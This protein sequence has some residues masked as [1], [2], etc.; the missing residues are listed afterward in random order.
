MELVDVIEDAGK[1]GKDLNREGVKELMDS[2][3]GRQVNA[4]IV[5]KL[6]PSQG[7]SS[8]PLTS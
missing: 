3:K 8:I 7:R 5:Y 6:D 1:S 2:I 4:V